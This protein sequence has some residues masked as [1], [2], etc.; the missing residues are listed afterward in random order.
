MQIN[1]NQPNFR[2]K[3]TGLYFGTFTSKGP[4]YDTFLKM[5]KFTKVFF[6]TLKVIYSKIYF[7]K[8]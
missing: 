8:K 5:D 1:L 3:G 6:L 7:E 4:N 2:S